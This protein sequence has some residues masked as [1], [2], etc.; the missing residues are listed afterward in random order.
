MSEPRQY[1]LIYV[2]A[3]D[4]DDAGV[5]ELHTRVEGIVTAGGGQID[6]TD[7]WGRRRLAYEIDRHRE[8]TYVLELFTGTGAIVAELDRRLKV[9]DN[10]LRYL[11]VRV[12][13]DL[14]KAER[15]RAKRQAKRQRRQGARG[16]AA[17]PKS[18]PTEETAP[19]ES[20]ATEETA[21]AEAA[22][23]EETAVTEE[24]GDQPAPAAEVSE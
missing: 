13:E 10:V 7:N 19:P 1:E 15:A 9:A 4:V 21:V 16:S 17:P 8:G 3:P 6:K 2:I 11:I 18:V 22:A 12:D 14:R 23:A 24:S 20:V 5:A